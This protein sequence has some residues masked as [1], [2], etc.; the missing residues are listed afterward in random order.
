ME[1]LYPFL[2]PL[3]EAIAVVVLIIAALSGFIINQRRERREHTQV[4]LAKVVD[5]E[6][7]AHAD[8]VLYELMAKR[9][10]F[11]TCDFNPEDVRFAD[12]LPDDIHK[13][14][15]LTLNYY[16]HVAASYLWGTLDRKFVRTVRGCQIRRIYLFFEPYIEDMRRLLARP[17]L[18]RELETLVKTDLVA[19]DEEDAELRERMAAR[20]ARQMSKD[21]RNP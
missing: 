21:P 2:E 4:L 16:Q 5:S 10:A 12:D 11:G 19:V 15:R 6:P 18:Y 8:Y 7:L 17:N 13:H 14:I 9:E 20:V 3:V 1:S